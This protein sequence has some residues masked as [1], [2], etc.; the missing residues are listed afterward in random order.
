MNSKPRHEVRNLGAMRQPALFEMACHHF[1]SLISLFPDRVPEWI[2][3]DGFT[4]SWSQYAGPCMVNALIRMSAGLHVSYHGGFSSQGP[5]YELRPEGSKG[6]LRCRG[7]HMSRDEMDYAFATHEEGEFALVDIDSSVPLESPFT[8]FLEIWH[9]YLNGGA[10]PPF[11]GRNNLKAF[12]ML[13]AAI[14]S[15]ETGSPVDIGAREEYAAA[16][17]R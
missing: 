11:S 16:V 5:M 3:C 17:G 1:D 14:E 8:R 13:S 15:I 9:A 7:I 4:P 12:V 2:S 10:D 6:S